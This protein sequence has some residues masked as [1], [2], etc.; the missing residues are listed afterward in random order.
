MVG[1]ADGALLRAVA[2]SY[3]LPLALML[4][5]AVVGGNSGSEGLAVVGAVSGLAVGWGGLRILDCHLLRREPLLT[6]RIKP[7]VVRLHKD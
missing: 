1:V 2:V 3:G 7:A 5:G 4:L 6:L